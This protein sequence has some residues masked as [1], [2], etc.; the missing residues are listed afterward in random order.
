[1]PPN[2]STVNLL[3]LLR[4]NVEEGLLQLLEV[5]ATSQ[6]LQIGRQKSTT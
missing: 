1:M 5:I 3:P 2:C 4:V 6:D